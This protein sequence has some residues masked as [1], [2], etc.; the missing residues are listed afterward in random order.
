MTRTFPDPLH[1]GPSPLGPENFE[2]MRAGALMIKMITPDPS[3]SLRAGDVV[4]VTAE[5]T[6]HQTP[7]LNAEDLDALLA[8]KILTRAAP[9]GPRGL[10]PAPDLNAKVVGY[11]KQG[12][13]HI[14]SFEAVCGRWRF[15]DRRWSPSR[16]GEETFIHRHRA[17]RPRGPVDQP[18]RSRALQAR[19]L[20]FKS[21]PVHLPRN[22]RRVMARRPS[23]PP[24]N[25]SSPAGRSPSPSAP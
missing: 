2:A 24:W 6:P 23:P 21:P 25:R 9:P 4:A 15:L 3:Q 10:P 18:G 17:A 8:G 13:D 20:G 11:R 5:P 1:L 14:Y 7:P 22:P 16:R 12:A 19:S